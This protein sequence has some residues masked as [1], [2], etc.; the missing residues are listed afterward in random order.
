MNKKS[1]FGCYVFLAISAVMAGG[2]ALSQSA[3]MQSDDSAQLLSLSTTLTAVTPPPLPG[4]VNGEEKTIYSGTRTLTYD[5]LTRG[6]ITADIDEFKRLSLATLNDERGWTRLGLTFKEVE[7]NGDF[8]LVL[9]SADQMTSFSALGCHPLWS[10]NVGRYVIVNQ[11]RWLGAT[12]PWNAAG[13]NLRNY[14]HMVVNHEVGHNLGRGHAD[15]TSAGSLAAVMQQQSYDLQ[16][17]E[18]NPWPLPSEVVRRAE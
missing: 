3:T 18:F 4:Y 16:G 14:R 2:M 11:D 8:T 17:C 5:V 12:D 10:C 13:G 6:S 1:I 7:A 15:C 9:A